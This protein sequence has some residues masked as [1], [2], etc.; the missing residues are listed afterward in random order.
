MVPPVVGDVIAT[1]GSDPTMT[2][3]GA[4]VVVAVVLVVEAMTL[5]LSS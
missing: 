3:V 1:V 2:V 5:F 4:G